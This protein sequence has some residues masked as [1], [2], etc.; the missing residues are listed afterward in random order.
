[1]TTEQTESY[2][3]PA[4]ILAQV[5]GILL[6][7]KWWLIIP[8]IVLL[9]VGVAA[10]YL[11][12]ALYRSSATLLVES[13]DV[14][15]DTQVSGSSEVVDERLAKIRQQILSRRDLIQL[16]D[17]YALYQ[18]ERQSDPL[19]KVVGKFH[20][21]IAVTPVS[22]EFQQSGGKATIAFTISYDYRD[23]ILAQQVTQSLI[24]RIVEI[25]ST[26]NVDQSRAAVAF[27]SQQTE[28][29]QGQITLVQTQLSSLK[30]Q[31]GSVL[32]NIN[33]SMMGGGGGADAQIAMLQRDNANLNQQ[34]DLVKTS[35]ERDPVVSQAEA[36]LAAA[37]AV[38][39]DN[40]PDVIFAKQR[41]EE[42]N[43]L[44]ASNVKKVPVDSIA[45]Q[46]AFNNT[47]IAAL[48]KA[49]AMDMSRSSQIYSA[50]S[51]GPAVMEAAAQMQQRLD[52]LNNQYQQSS[53][54]LIAAQAAA[55]AAT[56]QRG[57][58]LVVVDAPSQPDQPTSPNRPMLMAGGGVVGAGV[59]L[60]LILLM[61]LLR[62]PIRGSSGLEAVTGVTPLG[63][64]PIIT[65]KK[66]KNEPSDDDDGGRWLW[67][68][69]L[70]PLSWRRSK[71][72][73]ADG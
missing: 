35:A 45:Q 11:I 15:I 41:L 52:G 25:D 1:M 69:R 3:E 59:G 66:A 22:A 62:R 34:R 16:M 30:A 36:G 68:K 71:V 72:A 6:Q 49:K 28:D 8:T 65:T 48:Q 56:E 4:S 37:K 31:N 27:L 12:P 63:I 2:A 70:N 58:R 17:K 5:P 47:Q 32:S 39:A 21:A 9:I 55:R 60:A 40:H 57:E 43:R 33:T 50:Q 13:A 18:N 61:E 23:P 10:A 44:A 54:R 29:L 20:D 38:Y 14:P 73:M 46:I 67:L 51:R 19:S 64:I 53:T 42:A 26:T 24:D 7:R